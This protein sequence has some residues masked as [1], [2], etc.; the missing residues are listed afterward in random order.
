VPIRATL[1]AE[2][3][4]SLG[5][6]LIP[7]LT[8]ADAANDIF[9]GYILS[10]II[11]AGRTEGATVSFRDVHG[12]VPTTFVFR[13]SP[14]HIFWTRQPYCYALIEFPGKPN[15]EAHIGIYVGGKSR[16]PH[17]CDVAVLFQDEAQ[18][19]RLNLVPPRYSEVIL[20][21]ECKFYSSGLKL[22]L[23]RSFMGLS[24]DLT[25]KYS[26]FVVN[27][28][29]QSIERL[30]THHGKNWEHEIVPASPVAVSRLRGAFQKDFRNFKARY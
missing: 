18:L 3:Q 27:A 25:S 1:L 7:S 24:S 5:P 22:D 14:G 30:L 20:S 9:E 21:V 19:C 16:I 6:A 23:A 12:N 8:S 17:E 15:L 10:L 4:A 29:S 2:I 11:E 28:N 13:T 26:Y